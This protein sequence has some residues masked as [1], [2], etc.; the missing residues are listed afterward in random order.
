MLLILLGL[1]IFLVGVVLF[2]YPTFSQWYNAKDQS[3]VIA[4]YADHVEDMD[5]E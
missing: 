2:A 5:D 3:D 1:L 4:E